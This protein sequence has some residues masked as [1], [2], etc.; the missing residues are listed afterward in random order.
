MLCTLSQSSIFGSSGL[1]KE[2]L[3]YDD[4]V[5]TAFRRPR[6]YPTCVLYRQA[7]SDINLRTDSS[8]NGVYV[9]TFF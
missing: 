7:G 1:Q 6:S 2:A 3:G 8:D 4:L 5:V 9:A